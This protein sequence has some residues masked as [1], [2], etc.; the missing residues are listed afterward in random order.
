MRVSSRAAGEKGQ[1]RPK[2][3]PFQAKRSVSAAGLSC[4][5]RSMDIRDP[6]A[7][8]GPAQAPQPMHRFAWTMSRG[9]TRGGR[10]ASAKGGIQVG[11]RALPKQ[12]DAMGD[13]RV[14]RRVQQDGYGARL[15][16]G[17]DE[18]LRRA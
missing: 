11:L 8:P 10:L 9:L 7:P 2:P 3:A 16:R 5:S 13:G 6:P 1:M 4:P 17:V 14:E 12:A 18:P 15:A